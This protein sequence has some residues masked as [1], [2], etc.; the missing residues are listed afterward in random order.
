MR[1]SIIR[2]SASSIRLLPPRQQFSLQR[3]LGQVQ[4]DA[5]N[6]GA[7]GS[8][9]VCNGCRRGGHN[10]LVIHES[11]SKTDEINLLR[12]QLEAFEQ[13]VHSLE[14]LNATLAQLSDKVNTLSPRLELLVEAAQ[15]AKAEA[16][17]FR[18]DVRG[19]QGN[20]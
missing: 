13:K 17:V 12:G 4:A 9:P 14:D 19:L 7:P 3:L 11:R 1:R 6:P 8:F 15:E 10:V 18:R 5:A 16:V 20:T 2:M